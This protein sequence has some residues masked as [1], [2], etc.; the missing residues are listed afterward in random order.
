VR[1]LD[2]PQRFLVVSLTDHLWSARLLFKVTG[3][4]LA[5]CRGRTCCLGLHSLE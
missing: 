1:G 5:T 2:L 4:D 3:R